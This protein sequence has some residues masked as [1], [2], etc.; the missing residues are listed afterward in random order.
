MTNKMRKLHLKHVQER[1]HSLVE[2]DLVSKPPRGWIRFMREALGMS[3]RALAK[4]VGVSPNT[5]SEAEKAEKDET[6]TIKRLRR[7][8]D[9]MNCDLVYYLLP[10]TDIQTMIDERA[11][12]VATQKVREAQGHMEL[13]NQ[14]VSKSYLNDQIEEEFEKIKHSK[15]LWDDE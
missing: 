13:E 8:A 14:G 11:R 3:S 9:S 5:L 4:K 10:R 12:H 15:K 2:N 1:L 6:I 7:V